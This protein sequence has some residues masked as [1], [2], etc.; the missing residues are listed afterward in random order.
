MVTSFFD[1]LEVSFTGFLHSKKWSDRT[2]FAIFEPHF[3]WFFSWFCKN[4]TFSLIYLNMD[5]SNSYSMKF[6]LTWKILLLK[7][8][9][10]YNKDKTIKWFLNIDFVVFLLRKLIL[11]HVRDSSWWSHFL[12]NLRWFSLGSC[13]VKFCLIGR[14]L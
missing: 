3:Y 13:I 4:V 8:R 2:I 5:H 9:K 10:L 1:Q 12:T 6:Y 7:N 11:K 14:F